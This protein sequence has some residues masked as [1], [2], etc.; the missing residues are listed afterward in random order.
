MPE[1]LAKET[2]LP[3]VNPSVSGAMASAFMSQP[4]PLT[5]NSCFQQCQNRLSSQKGDAENAP[6]KQIK[7]TWNLKKLPWKRETPCK[8]ITFPHIKH[9]S[10][11]N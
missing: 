4:V 1:N 9:G 3:T 8:K 10:E 6:R 11:K 2:H 7:Q 5:L